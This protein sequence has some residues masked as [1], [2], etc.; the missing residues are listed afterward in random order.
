M[1]LTA[2]EITRI[3]ADSMGLRRVTAKSYERFGST[4]S[5]EVWIHMDKLKDGSVYHYNPIHDDMQNAQLEWWLIARGQLV[6]HNNSMRFW[7]GPE[8]EALRFDCSTIEEKR[9]AICECVAKLRK[10]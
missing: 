8:G 5:R 9:R 10:P 3:C 2:V 7:P 1:K 6:F 4:D